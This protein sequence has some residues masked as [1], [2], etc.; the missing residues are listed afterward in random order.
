M[1][2]ANVT[3]TVREATPTVRVIDITGEI[4]GFSEKEISA[5]HDEASQ[6]GVAAVVLNFEG[7]E[8]MNS[9]GIGLLVTTLIRAQRS[10][11]RLMA[12]GL[13]DHYCQIFSLTRLD[14]A[15][16]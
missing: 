6:G 16:E 12:Y 1:P 9:G 4:T 5:A 8:Y 3:M 7:L 13:T 15:I 14:E 2:T 11:H 10:G